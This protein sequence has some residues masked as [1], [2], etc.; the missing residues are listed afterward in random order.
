MSYKQ[1]TGSVEGGGGIL[2]GQCVFNSSG[3]LAQGPPKGIISGVKRWNPSLGKGVAPLR[4][5]AKSVR[6]Q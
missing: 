6:A 2:L 3:P 1:S 4:T 5:A